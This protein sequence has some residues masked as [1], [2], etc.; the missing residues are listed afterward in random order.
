ML[1]ESFKIDLNRK[2]IKS[3]GRSLTFKDIIDIQLIEI[4]SVATED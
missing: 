3:D 4:E 1:L 2:H